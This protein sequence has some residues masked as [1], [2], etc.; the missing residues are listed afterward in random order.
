L[1][2][3]EGFGPLARD[4][5]WKHPQAKRGT[6]VV[7]VSWVSWVVGD[8]AEKAKEIAEKR[9]W[10]RKSFQEL[11]VKL[12]EAIEAPGEVER[13]F[14]V[15]YQ[16]VVDEYEVKVYKLVWNG[17]LLRI[18]VESEYG[19]STLFKVF[20]LDGEKFEVYRDNMSIRE[21]RE[22][23][24]SFNSVLQGL[25]EQVIK[26]DKELSDIKVKLEKLLRAVQ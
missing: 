16:R 14:E 7:W 19:S 25:L 24:D 9:T 11:M 22:F 17:S 2:L 23:L 3:P 20:K 1:R 4:E 21:I 26:Y 8:I 12:A 15:E 10:I 6:R 18:R 13:V 5:G